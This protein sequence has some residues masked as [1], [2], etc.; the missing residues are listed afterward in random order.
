M[1]KKNKVQAF[2]IDF[3]HKNRQNEEV[4]ESTQEVKK[5]AFGNF[6]IDIRKDNWYTQT[7]GLWINPRIRF[8]IGKALFGRHVVIRAKQ[9]EESDG[10]EL[11]K[12][13]AFPIPYTTFTF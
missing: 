9:C 10:E 8:I 5:S 7:V 4:W 3:F 12:R 1:N 13:I 11:M 6:L 2:S